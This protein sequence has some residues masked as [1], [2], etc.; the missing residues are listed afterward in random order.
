MRIANLTDYKEKE[1]LSG[2]ELARKLGI[3]DAHLSMIIS[4]KRTPSRKLAQRI[5]T[6]T[7]IPVLNLLYPQRNGQPEARG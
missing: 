7:G 3:T 4:G 1:D 2:A 6:L 5:S